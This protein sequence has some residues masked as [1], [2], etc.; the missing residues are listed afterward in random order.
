MKCPNCQFDNPSDAN[1][2][3]QCGGKLDS[4][5]P[6]CGKKKPKGSKFCNQCGLSFDIQIDPSSRAQ[7]S[8][9][10]DS[11]IEMPKLVPASE[12]E[13][14]Q[15]TIVF[16]D[17]SGYTLM[18]ERLDPEDVEAIMSR[19]KIEAVNIVESHKGIVNQFVGDEVLALF[20]IPTTH[21]DDSIRAINAALEIH[22]LVSQISPEIERMTGAQLRM[23]TG[24]STGLVVTHTRDI[25]DGSYGITG[26][27]VNIGARLAAIAKIDEILICPETHNVIEPFF[28]TKALEALQVKGKTAP[29]IPYRV[30]GQSPVQTRFE[31]AKNRGLTNFT[32]REHEFETLNSCL[33]KMLTGRGQFIT[34]AGE[35]GFGKSRLIYEFRHRLNRSKIAVLQGRCQS[36]GSDTPYIPHNNA[37]K[38]GLSLREDDTP[39]QL[40]EKI[41]SN[42]LEVDPS[43]EQYLHIY[44]HLL[45]VPSE[46]YPL[47]KQLHGQELIDAIHE[48][49]AAINILNAKER[50]YIAIMEDWHWA[51]EASTAALKHIISVIPSHKVMLI[52]IYRP[53]L[54]TNWSHWSH[55]TSIFLNPLDD[56]N[57]SQ[58]IKSV[59]D[60]DY[61]P[62]GIAYLVQKRT[63]G[64]PFFMEEICNGLVEED[65][66]RLEGRQAVFNQSLEKL[67]LPSTVQAVIR[68]RIDRLD[69]YNR[70]SLRLASVIGREFSHRIL[71][72]ILTF[73]ERLSQTIENLKLLE[74]IQ[75]I[76]VIPE[77]EYM[78]KH[79][80]TQ[81]V[82]YE[83]LLLKR[84]KELHDLVGCAIE[85]LYAD[86]IEEHVSLLYRHFSR[87]EKWDKAA[88][89][90]RKAANRAYRL[91]QFKE[92][93][94]MFDK[95]RIC[96]SKMTADR[97]NQ[98]K[99][100][101]LL[102]EMLWPLQFLGQQDWAL[103]I[104]REAE[105]IAGILNDPMRVGKIYFEY[106]LLHFFKNH[107]DQAEKF[108]LKILHHPVKG[109]ID[110]LIWTVKFPLAVTYFSIGN[111]GEAASLY[112]DV[113]L[114]R[115]KS[116]TVKEYS[117]ELP[118]LPYTHAC[119]HLAYI[120]A[121]QGRIKEAKELILKSHTPALNT[122]S[123]LQS[124]VYCTLWHS[125][126][127]A[128]I[129]EDFGV[130][131]RVTGTLET[132]KKTDSPILLFLLYAAQGNAFKAIREFKSAKLAYQNSLKRIAGTAHRRY[133]DDVYHNL[134]ETLL[135]LEEYQSAR[136]FH[137]EA[138][139]LI[140]LDPVINAA[141]FDYLKGR[142]LSSVKTPDFEQ[143]ETL[144]LKSINADEKAGAVVLAAQKRF[145]L[146]GML[147]GKGEND[148]SRTILTNLQLLFGSWDIPAWQR[149]CD[150]ALE[151]P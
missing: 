125:A 135:A 149:K 115:E 29:M 51:D 102:L 120:R 94:S 37:L 96:F 101:D 79:V 22:K 109:E 92:S 111:W 7:H 75:Q 74:L 126:L 76:R 78:F 136:Q 28:E 73:K 91:G 148:R 62:E 110:K 40:H 98:E 88:E 27:A 24:I 2:C 60:V 132:A 66:V 19:I 69:H 85:E 147:M 43:L 124:L 67:K 82:T 39:A 58:I 99:L 127:S 106:G 4:S 30:T 50:P 77:S 16:S 33:E 130:S 35:A 121:L 55:H 114:S 17:L 13:R 116:G 6:Q 9:R 80:I 133:L 18:N 31:A 45:S 5:C 143:A 112:S 122:I 36:Y 65:K 95:V 48:A 90:G 64:N 113:I 71:E 134:I 105:S 128:L 26:D 23:H 25:R 87:A 142:L 84:R 14:R 1:F 137:A 139:P 46:V 11:E 68:A 118:F 117:E 44:L 145:Y 107:Y 54:E 144:F 49:L 108:Y 12:G 150:Q 138:L 97:N 38:R 72:Q 41:M 57:C 3:N 151:T 119:H 53:D 63:D 81:E 131:E 47:S 86:R 10:K 52:V 103:K 129:E 140:S 21:E 8:S 123:N 34:V 20:G 42:V 100:V 93:V 89:Y 32:G 70:E 59:W 83:T 141:R 104:C 56:Q 61:I 15:A 146:A